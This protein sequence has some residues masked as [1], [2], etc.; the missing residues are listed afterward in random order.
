MEEDEDSFELEVFEVKDE[1]E[2]PEVE[3]RTK[4]KRKKKSKHRSSGGSI[5]SCGPQRSRSGL[6]VCSSRESHEPQQQPLV[7]H[8]TTPGSDSA[9]ATTAASTPVEAAGP[10]LT[11]RPPSSFRASLLSVLGKL[12][13][14]GSTRHRAPPPQ[15]SPPTPP[16]QALPSD[17]CEYL[18]GFLGGGRPGEFVEFPHQ[19]YW[20][21]Q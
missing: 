2:T 5:S 11:T 1:D 6:S 18:R 13:W 16:L 12:V 19:T 9:R 20:I 15:Q 4:K 21:I 10:A 17:Q 8:I 7:P 3:R 14:R